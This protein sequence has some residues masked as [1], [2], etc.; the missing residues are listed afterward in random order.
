MT[1][2]GHGRLCQC[3]PC[4]A[5]RAKIVAPA[6]TTLPRKGRKKGGGVMIRD[7][8]QMNGARREAGLRLLETTTVR[9]T[10]KLTVRA[11]PK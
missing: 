4:R 9:E 11:A 2:E 10:A 7:G 8:S 5:E 1:R 3:I 6:K